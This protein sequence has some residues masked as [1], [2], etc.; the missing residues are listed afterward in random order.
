MLIALAFFVRRLV[1]GWPHWAK[2]PLNFWL[3]R[4]GDPP[5]DP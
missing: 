2:S 3:R 4:Y 1:R 5:S